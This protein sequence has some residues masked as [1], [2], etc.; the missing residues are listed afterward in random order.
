MPFLKKSMFKLQIFVFDLF[1]LKFL[2]RN[3]QGPR[4]VYLLLTIN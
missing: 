3:E 1:R 2:D 4:I